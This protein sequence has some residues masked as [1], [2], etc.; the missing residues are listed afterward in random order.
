MIEIPSIEPAVIPCIDRNAVNIVKIK[1]VIYLNVLLKNDVN[2]SSFIVF[3]RLD[4]TLKII[5][6]IK[7]GI[8][9]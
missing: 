1:P 5:E 6:N 4:T 3:E 7:S 8:R 9:T 2:L